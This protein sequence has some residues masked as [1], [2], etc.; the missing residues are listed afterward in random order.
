MLF[1]EN[2]NLKLSA[3]KEDIVIFTVQ[4]TAHYL[5]GL[6][7]FQD[8]PFIGQGPRMFRLLCDKERFYVVLQSKKSCSSHPHNTYIQLLA[9]IGLVELFYSVYF[10]FH[11]TYLFLKH[12]IFNIFLKKYFE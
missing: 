1:D 5:S 12:F 6:K 10:F 8:K 7:M 9:E 3:N 4:H 2:N 11:I